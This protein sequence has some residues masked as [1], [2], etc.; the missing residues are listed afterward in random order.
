MTKKWWKTKRS[1]HVHLDSE[2]TSYCRYHDTCVVEWTKDNIVLRTGG[3]Y[4]LTTKTRMNE[5]SSEYFNH[6]FTVFQSKGDWF[7]TLRTGHYCED[8]K[9]TIP[10]EE[11]MTIPRDSTYDPHSGE[12]SDCNLK[13]LAHPP[14]QMMRAG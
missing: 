3:Y 6:L 2:G 13:I 14:R 10:F 1:T 11:G 9:R 8:G 5:C 12:C 4:T 7:V